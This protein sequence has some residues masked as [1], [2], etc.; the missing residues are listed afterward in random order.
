MTLSTQTYFLLVMAKTLYR[1]HNAGV[2]EG[3]AG[4]R[5]FVREWEPRFVGL[6]RNV[7]SC[8]RKDDIPT[9]LPADEE[10]AHESQSSETAIDDIMTNVDVLRMEDGRVKAC[11]IR[12]S[13]RNTSWIQMRKEILEITRTQQYTDSNLVPV[14]IGVQPKSKGKSKHGKDA[15]NESSEKVKDDDRRKC[16][17]CRETGHARSQSRTKLKNLI[18]A[19]GKPVTAKFRPSGTA[20]VAPLADDHA[21]TLFVT[22]PHVKR[23]SSCACA[24]IET[25]MRSHAGCTAPTGSERVKLISAI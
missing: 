16:D 25:T 6:L 7:L 5:P 2:N 4:R 20:A 22:V 18:D 9:Q 1:C 19:E 21:T 24:K 12:E 3:F 14:Q 8:R 13:T 15:K 17:Y 10:L 23:K 11:L